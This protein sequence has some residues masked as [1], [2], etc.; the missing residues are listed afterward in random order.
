LYFVLPAASLSP[1]FFAPD[2]PS[3]MVRASETI[4][5]GSDVQT[6]FQCYSTLAARRH[7][8][9]IQIAPQSAGAFPA[10][11]IVPWG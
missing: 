8:R 7:T 9:F 6:P 10:L 1:V 4:K 5:R 3:G 11:T 2:G